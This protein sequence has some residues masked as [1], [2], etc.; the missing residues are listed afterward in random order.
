[1][2]TRFESDWTAGA[3]AILFERCGGC[4]HVAYFARGFCP[5]C[6]SSKVHRETAS[7]EGTVYAITEVAR[8]PTQELRAHAPYAL[9]LV[10]MAEGFRMMAHGRPGLRI[11]EPVR[12]RFVRVAGRLVPCFQPRR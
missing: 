5:A 11:G 6:G 9:L 4:G 8:A 1:M 2:N 10:D 3:E 12:V 7:G